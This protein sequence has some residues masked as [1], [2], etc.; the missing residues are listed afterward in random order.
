M[1][2]KIVED[3]K[4]IKPGATLESFDFIKTH[5]SSIKRLLKIQDAIA[6]S[7]THKFFANFMLKRVVEEARRRRGAE[8][9]K[10][11][12]AVAAVPEYLFGQGYSLVFTMGNAKEKFER[13]QAHVQQVFELDSLLKSNFLFTPNLNIL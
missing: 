7:Y 13:V 12:E 6:A 1:V 8:E 9:H 2:I 10:Q 4:K 11:A 3:S 5:A